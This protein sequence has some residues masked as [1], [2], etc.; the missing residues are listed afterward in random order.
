MPSVHSRCLLDIE[1]YKSFGSLLLL[2][3]RCS[4]VTGVEQVV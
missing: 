1:A 2:Y 3:Q 4:L